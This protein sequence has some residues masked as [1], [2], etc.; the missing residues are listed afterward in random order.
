MAINVIN[1]TQTVILEVATIVGPKGDKGDAGTGSG[2]PSPVQSVQGKIGAIV[3]APSDIGAADVGHTHPIATA[4][5]D[6][7]LSKTD[8]VKLDGLSN[9]P[10]INPVTST[11]NGLMLSAD[12]VKLDG[13]ADNATANSTDVIL[14]DRAN[15]TGVQ[16]IST[17]T[18]L[19]AAI[20]TKYSKATAGIPKTDLDTATQTSLTNAD[21]LVSTTVPA[22]QT[23]LAG[24]ATSAQ[25]VKA[26]TALQNIAGM[27]T[28]FTAGTAAEQAAFQSS[29]SGDRAKL[30]MQQQAQ[31]TAGATT[32]LLNVGK[33]AL[34]DPVSGI[35]IPFA[36]AGVATVTLPSGSATL[37]AALA[38]TVRAVRQSASHKHCIILIDSDS[39]S[40]GLASATSPI[41]PYGG[42]L[43]NAATIL[44]ASLE[45]AGVK[46]NRTRW[47][48]QM[49][50]QV[51]GSS[52]GLTDPRVG[53]TYTETLNQSVVCG[54]WQT[55]TIGNKR[56]YTVDAPVDR[57][58]LILI[59]NGAGGTPGTITV[60]VNGGAVLYSFNEAVT[61][62]TVVS[63]PINLGALLRPGDVINVNATVGTVFEIGIMAWNSHQP[64]VTILN[65]G[66]SGKSAQQGAATGGFNSRS[67]YAA[68]NTAG[69]PA[70]LVLVSLILNSLANDSVTYQGYLQTL[71]TLIKAASSTTDVVFYDGPQCGAGQANSANF[72]TRL[73]DAKT[74]AAANNCAYISMNQVFGPSPGTGNT[75]YIADNVGHMTPLGY[76]EMYR[77]LARPIV[78]AVKSI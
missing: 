63:A 55:I 8:K 3:L 53:G 65:N 16:A 70:S 19:Q 54:G 15:H 78:D 32:A 23:A 22:L 74:V 30:T 38:N 71:Y 25:G 36:A 12:K 7:L 11:V 61:G 27:Q 43:L 33:T 24:K 40:N 13:I 76:E 68:L 35:D 37:A 39:T 66:G 29:V 1:P 47:A 46:V 69:T 72:P 44:G 26:D 56:S 73:A 77:G 5:V 58:Q 57:A 41:Y 42:N 75:W 50:Q 60:D 62:S 48:G 64:G 59:T 2:T 51:L 45:S 34:V 18:G 9:S 49:S 67:L 21:T 52:N 14:K 28:A 10:V 31:Q 4:I 20:D 6:G 17:I